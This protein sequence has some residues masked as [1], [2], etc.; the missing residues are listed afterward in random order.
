MK[1]LFLVA[2]LVGLATSSTVQLR[3][4]PPSDAA[5]GR[6]L[7]QRYADAIVGV[8]LVVTLKMKMGEREQP[9]RE[10]RIEINGT[11]ISPTGLTVT[12]LSEVDPQVAFDAVRAAAQVPKPRLRRAQLPFGA[13][14]SDRRAALHPR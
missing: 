10:Q 7:V 13:A 14:E 12:T 2:A 3:A 1:R 9:P 11:V 5:A 6:A 8:E 4:V